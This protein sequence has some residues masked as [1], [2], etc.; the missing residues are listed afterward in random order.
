MATTKDYGIGEFDFPR[1]WFMIADS[2]DVGS[3]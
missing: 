3:D 1:G 2:H